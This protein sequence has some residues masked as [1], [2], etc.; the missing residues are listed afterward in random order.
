[1]LKTVKL[2][3]YRL[4]GLLTLI[5]LCFPICTQAQFADFGLGEKAPVE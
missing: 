5:T 3:K 4:C 2:Y 1:M